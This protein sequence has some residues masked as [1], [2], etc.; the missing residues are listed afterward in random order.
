MPVRIKITLFFTLIVFVILSL[1]CSAVYY[2]SYINRQNYFNTQLTNRAVTTARLLSQSETFNHDLIQKINA[3][4]ALSMTDKCIQVYNFSDE[5]IYAYA[6]EAGDT[7]VV[8]KQILE[9]AKQKEYVYFSEKNKDA[10]GYHYADKNIDVLIIIA[11]YDAAGKKSLQ[12]LLYILLSCFIG[13]ILIALA[14]GYFFTS[15]LL[16]PVRKIA[17]ELNNISAQDLTRRIDTNKNKDEWTYLTN[18]LNKLLDRLAESFDT[19]RRFI[20]NASHELSTPLTSVSSQLE[21]SLQN[22]R[23]AGEYRKVMQ[24]VLQDVKHLSKLTQTLLQFAKAS[25]TAAGLEIN[26]VR[27]DEILLRLPRDMAK[28]NNNYVVKLSFNELPDEEEKMLIFGNEDLLF[29]AI[30]NIV[31]NACKYSH[32]QATKIN[33]SVKQNEIIVEI[34]DEGIGIAQDELKNIFQPFFRTGDQKNET[35]FGLGL[36]LTSRIIKLH[37]GYINVHSVINKGTTFTVYL[38]VASSI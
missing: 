13:G 38:P 29:V 2:F 37:R 6:D 16:R 9:T 5:R 12:Q 33:L 34:S 32:N 4:T 11:A 17:D 30:R 24:S 7:I 14:G 35:G 25:G 22:E 19:Q 23:N 10:A 21:V 15:G 26:L 28:L 1:F 27:I 8:D 3:S 31:L 20:A 18:T 36:S